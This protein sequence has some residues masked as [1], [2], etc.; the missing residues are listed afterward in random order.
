V[1][2]ILTSSPPSHS[3]LKT[4]DTDGVL[5]VTIRVLSNEQEGDEM[6]LI[7]EA[8]EFPNGVSRA[9]IFLAPFRYVNSASQY[10]VLSVMKNI[11]TFRCCT[12]SVLSN[13]GRQL[14]GSWTRQ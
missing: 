12:V 13:L 3:S 14:P 1:P 5:P 10:V 4:E 9:K 8:G 2:L 6:A 11:L 7:L